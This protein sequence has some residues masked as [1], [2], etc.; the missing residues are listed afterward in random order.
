M[1]GVAIA[2]VAKAAVAVAYPVVLG[3]K[4]FQVSDYVT[5]RADDLLIPGRRVVRQGELFLKFV[6]L[7][8]ASCCAWLLQSSLDPI[9]G[10]IFSVL[11][12]LVACFVCGDI[13]ASIVHNSNE[14]EAER[15]HQQRLRQLE[16]NKKQQNDSKCRIL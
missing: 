13:I 5:R 15:Q 11:L 9:V 2:E 12:P 1:A 3:W 14:D 8:I 6:C 16:L 7:F 10:S 4:I